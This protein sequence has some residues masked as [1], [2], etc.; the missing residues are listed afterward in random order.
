MT[1]KLA[2]NFIYFYE[3]FQV[4]S[5]AFLVH[6]LFLHL[7]F[8]VVVIRNQIALSTHT[9][10]IWPSTWF[11]GKTNS[12]EKVWQCHNF[13]SLWQE[14]LFTYWK[15]IFC[16]TF[17]TEGDSTT[18]I[19]FCFYNEPYAITQEDHQQTRIYTINKLPTN[20]PLCLPP[21]NTGHVKYDEALRTLFH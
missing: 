12:D 14:S 18:T 1:S 7:I 13:F 5:K 15:H 2:F 11:P 20:V 3:S 9:Y 10:S 19:P 4:V 6:S 21:S 17:P 8:H 16:S